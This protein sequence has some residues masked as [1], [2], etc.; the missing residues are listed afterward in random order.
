MEKKW[1]ALS[2]EEKREE[3]FKRWLSP[4]DAKFSSPEAEKAYKQRVTRFIKAIK[5]EE[6]DRVPVMLPVGFYPAYYAGFNLQTVMYDYDALKKAWL[7]FMNDFSDMDTFGGPGLVIPARALE[8]IDHKLHKWPGH[9]LFDDVGSYQ[10]IEAEYMKA[11]EYDK[12]IDDPSDFWLRTFMPREAGVF[13]ALA[14]LP[15]LTPFIGIPLSYLSHF[16]D[17][18]VE[19]TLQTMIAAGKEVRR[20]QEVVGEVSRITFEAGYPRFGLGGAGAPF[21]FLAD[22]CRGT[23]GIMMDVYRQPEK[24]HEAMERLT[25]IIIKT[26]VEAAND[27]ECPLLMTPLHKGDHNFMSPQQFETFYWPYFKKVMMG[28]IEEG[29]VPMPFAEGNYEPRLEII[30]DMPRSS[31]VWYFEQM[32]MAKAKKVLGD[33]ACI[34][35]NVPVSVLCTGTPREVKERCRQLIET[36]GKG[37][38]YIL[39]GSASI[40]K[41]NPDNLRAMM[42]AVREYGVYKK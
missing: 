15:H 37:G 9:G 32:D 23:K 30:K 19:A 1:S 13:K 25:P 10:F 6:P 17:P 34:A 5:L 8:M 42:A 28:V 36:C 18:E 3:R 14:K 31:V 35:G 24:I 40:D 21:D 16:A 41:G 29:L 12:L 2:W 7:K 11:D 33:T 22:M 38:G 26:A 27:S 4:P 20:W 39:A